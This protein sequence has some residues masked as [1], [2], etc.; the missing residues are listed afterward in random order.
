MNIADAIYQFCKKIGEQESLNLI[1]YFASRYSDAKLYEGISDEV[2]TGFI[3]DT[4]IPHKVAVYEAGV[5]VVT[6]C[7]GTFSPEDKWQYLIHDLSKFS[8][9]EL[10]TY[11]HHFSKKETAR[12]MKR[13]FPLAWH[14]HKICNEHHPEHWLSVSRAGLVTPLPMPAKFIMEMVAD[15]KG[16]AKVYGGGMES[17]MVENIPEMLMHDETK[18]QLNLVLEKLG[19]SVRA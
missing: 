16:A 12:E 18:I 4:L 7:N 19:Y 3:T 9:E 5:E 8:R 15:W 2:I 1:T 10:A 11:A 6:A 14:H 13:E 17:W